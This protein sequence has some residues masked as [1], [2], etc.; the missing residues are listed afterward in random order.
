MKK[1]HHAPATAN[2][3]LALCMIV[4]NAAENLGPC[5]ESVREAVDEI[6]VVDTGSTDDT[7]AIALR[8]GAKVFDF[9]W[10]GDFAAARNASIE[11]ATCDYILWLDGDDRIDPRELEKLKQFK[12][13]L[14]AAKNKAYFLTILN[15]FITANDVSFSQLRIF[16]RLPGA[17][18]EFPIHEQI[19][20]QL[21]R[22]G[23]GLVNVDLTVIHTGYHDPE[24]VKKKSERNLEIIRENLRHNPEDPFH[25]L[26]LA[27]TL[28]G[29]GRQAEAIP[30]LRKVW[31]TPGILAREPRLYVLSGMLLA[32]YSSDVGDYA[33]AEAVLRRYLQ[34]GPEEMELAYYLLSESLLKQKKYA[35]AADALQRS[36]AKPLVVGLFPINLGLVRFN[37][38]YYLGLAFNALGDRSRARGQ[39]E[40]SLG[41]PSDDFK[42]VL[43]LA[44]LDLQ[45]GRFESAAAL[46]QQGIAAAKTFATAAQYANLG[47]ALRKLG[48]NQEAL[49]ALKTALE[50]D[51]RRTEALTQAG[52]LHLELGAWDQALACF[53]KAHAEDPCLTDVK[54]VL[55]QLYWRK[56]DLD[57]TVRQC[58][59]LLQEMSLPAN[60]TLEGLPD[61]ARLYARVSERLA[62]QNRHELAQLADH[63]SFLIYPLPEVLRRLT[64]GIRPERNQAVI[65]ESLE[66]HARD[67]QAIAALKTALQAP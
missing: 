48:R 46:Y 36:L 51:P 53:E 28:G 34:D 6:I 21:Q 67:A 25:H 13:R 10:I 24:T 20:G 15:K 12:R 54:L 1:K 29:I 47:L 64:A 39:F 62:E 14:P 40:A 7:K 52:Y 38:H 60:Q 22:V 9:A 2:P 3:T 8:Y 17:R 50:M 33:E 44:A 27:R 31:E 5:L 4:K 35:E 26:Q 66:L 19:S 59:L 18:F 41:F 49:A 32:H 11:R 56:R 45:E 61:L 58:S 23:V 57:Q 30:H 63:A 43:E 37:Q 16:P 55:S 42:S 65:R